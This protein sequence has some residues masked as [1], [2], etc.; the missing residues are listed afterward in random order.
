MAWYAWTTIKNGDEVILPGTEVSAE[1]LGLNKEQW[2]QQVE[3]R[4]VRQKPYP[5]IPEGYTGSAKDFVL[6]KRREELDDLDDEFE[7]AEL[8]TDE[9]TSGNED[10][11]NPDTNPDTNESEVETP[12]RTDEW[13]G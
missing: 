1:S 10:E 8:E 12:T 5:D 13:S 3:S 2:A 4:V 6:K 11:E 7:P 9:E